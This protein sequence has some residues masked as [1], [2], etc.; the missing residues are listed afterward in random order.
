MNGLFLNWLELEKKE[1]SLGQ[2]LA[3]INEACG[4]NYKH[5][6]PSLMERKNYALERIPLSVR[7]YMM[8]KVLPELFTELSTEDIEK[9]V[10]S[11][12]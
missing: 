5:N 12:T 11:L 1:K 3:E 2:A 10:K 7:Q 4:T 8:R 6:W 9:L